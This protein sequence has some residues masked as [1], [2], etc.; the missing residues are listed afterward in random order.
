M[1][2]PLYKY[3]HIRIIDGMGQA[4]WFNNSASLAVTTANYIMNLMLNIT[5]VLE[6]CV[7]VLYIH[8]VVL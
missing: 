1:Y 3:Q 7:K 4:V 2:S 6:L 5:F 8:P